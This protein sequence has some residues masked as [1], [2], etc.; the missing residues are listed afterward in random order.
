M[1]RKPIA[2]LFS[3]GVE[4]AYRWKDSV[5]SADEIRL[6]TADLVANGMRPWFTK[7]AGTLHDP[8]WLRPVEEIFTWCH[9]AERYL[10]NERPAGPGRARV[11]AADRVVLRRRPRPGA[12]GGPVARLVPGARRGPHPVRDGARPLARRRSSRAVQDPDPAQHRGALRPPVRPARRFRPARRQPRGY[13]RDL[14]SRRVGRGARRLRPR[15]PV[16]RLVR[17]A[18][19]G[20]GA[21]LLPASRARDGAREPH[22]AGA[23]GRPADHQ[24]SVAARREGDPAVPEPAR[25]P[26][27]VVSRPAHG[28]GLPSAAPDGCPAG[29]PERDGQWPRRLLPLGRRPHVLGGAVGRPPQAPA[30]RGR[31]GHERGPAGERRPAPGCST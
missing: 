2:G 24:R 16:R 13:L 23:R 6:W 12:G 20:A 7:F 17:G 28:E 18:P 5:Q 19:R 4:E 27:P 26:D 25:H 31:L 9:G 14:A 21:Q 8:R 30:Q 29:L 11:L 22:A 3:V 10:R 1:G 15:R